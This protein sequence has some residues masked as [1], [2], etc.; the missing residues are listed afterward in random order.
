MTTLF[1]ALNALGTR[2]DLNYAWSDASAV[3][4]DIIGEGDTSLVESL[5]DE[6]ATRGLVRS[7]SGDCDAE[8]QLTREGSMYV[9]KETRLEGPQ[10]D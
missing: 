4:D 9:E 1:D 7:R 8:Y 3:T 10:L 5:L 2:E 6:A